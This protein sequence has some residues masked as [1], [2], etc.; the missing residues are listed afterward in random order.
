MSGVWLFVWRSGFCNCHPGGVP[1]LAGSEGQ[2]AFIPKSHKT[3][4]MRKTVLSRLPLPGH[5]TESRLKHTSS[6][7]EREVFYLSR[8]FGFRG[9][10]LVWHT[11]VYR[12][13]V[14]GWRLVN[15][16]W[17]FPSTLLHRAHDIIQK[18]AYILFSCSDFCVFYQ[19]MPLHHLALVASWDSACRFHETITNRETAT[20]RA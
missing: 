12:G 8:S 13:A 4:T 11:D 15:S 5:S 10:P 1:W 9:S 20:S 7:S 6:L 18:G 3:I 17:C 14:R 2:G 16:V 19:G